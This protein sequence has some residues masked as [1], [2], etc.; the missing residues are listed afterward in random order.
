[1]QMQTQLD[2]NPPGP[3]PRQRRL[4]R[5]VILGVAVVGGLAVWFYREPLRNRIAERAILANDAP[6]PEVVEEMIQ[7]AP[8][9]VAAV[10][11]AWNTGKIVHSAPARTMDSS[12]AGS[13]C[14]AL[15]TMQT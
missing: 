3:A 14:L 9:P 2:S 8:N 6:P 12:S 4:L 7:N 11:A 15:N 13:G 10:V 5:A 1:M